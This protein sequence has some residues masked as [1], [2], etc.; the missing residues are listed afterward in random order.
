MDTNDVVNDLFK[1]DKTIEVWKHD[2]QDGILGSPEVRL[3]LVI[4]DGQ[5][6][7]GPGA[8]VPGYPKYSL[9]VMTNSDF[10]RDKTKAEE[11]GYTC[12]RSLNTPKH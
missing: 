12:V 3:I 7:S 5:K 8:M 11:R 6:W 2:F 9:T 1:C 4:K 10:E